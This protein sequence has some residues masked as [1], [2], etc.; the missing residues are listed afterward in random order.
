MPDTDIAIAALADPHA[1]AIA[2]P[3]N[4]TKLYANAAPNNVG[5]SSANTKLIQ[6]Q[7]FQKLVKPEKQIKPEKASKALKKKSK[8]IEKASKV[9]EPP[10]PKPT[11]I[12]SRTR[13]TV[14]YSEEKSR[15]P[16]PKPHASAAPQIINISPN[17]QPSANII[18][19]ENNIPLESQSKHLTSDTNPIVASPTKNLAI[20]HPP[21]VLRISKVSTIFHLLM[22]YCNHSLID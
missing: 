11:R 17:Q 13:K 14:N 1:A 7:K 21:I 15:S 5:T 18:E 8:I 2:T 19:C 16:S 6:K 20:E 22:A 10:K 9:V 12:L 4:V 3:S